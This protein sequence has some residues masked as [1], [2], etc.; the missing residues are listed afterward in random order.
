MNLNKREFLQVLG[1]G[2]VSGMGLSA[3]AQA[4]AT[5][6]GQALYDVPAFGNVSLLH[7]TDCHAQLLPLYFRDARKLEMSEIGWALPWIYFMSGVGSVT[8]GWIATVDQVS[9]GR[10]ILGYGIGD[11]GAVV[12]LRIHTHV[13]QDAIRLFGFATALELQL[14]E[15]LIGISGIG[16]KVGLAVL[17][18]IEPSGLVTAIQR[19]DVARLVAI[20]GV[21]KKT[22]E[23]TNTDIK[24]FKDQLALGDMDTVTPR[25]EF[26][27]GKVIVEYSYREPYSGNEVVELS[28]GELEEIV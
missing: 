15:R 14:F 3:W 4:D 6:A 5:R 16:P 25:R 12:S 18:G 28:A 8:A 22:A 19:G 27:D 2:A 24:R 23:S 20:P 10:A 1:A 26:E 17:S 11:V 13:S 9:E 21:G 7:M